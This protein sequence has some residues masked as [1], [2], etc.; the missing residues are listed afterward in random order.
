MQS[1]IKQKF[2]TLTLATIAGLG[3][4]NQAYAIGFTGAYDPIN[5]VLTNDPAG[6]GTVDTMNAALG[7]ITL[8]GSND[9]TLQSQSTNTDFTIFIDPLSVPIRAGTISF[10]WE[11]FSLDTPGDDRAGYVLNGN[12]TVLATEDM[13]ASTA[14]V[15][16]A[17]QTGDTF[18][19][20]VATDENIGEAGEFTI[21]NFNFVPV[22]FEFSPVLGLLTLGGWAVIK[23]FRK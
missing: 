4:S 2:L 9:G 21:K 19:W 16:L 15:T 1:Q 23:K 20:R 10:D 13:Q 5:F 3:I 17:L 14:P 22:P 8:I 18:A 7:T 12:F 6:N 11:Y